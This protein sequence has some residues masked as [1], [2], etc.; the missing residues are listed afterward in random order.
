VSTESQQA[1]NQ[2]STLN[3]KPL[4]AALKTWYA[5]PGDRF[6]V[7]V[8]GFIVDIV[9]DELLVEIQTRNFSA[10]KRKLTELVAHHPVRLVHPIAREKWIVKVAEDQR[11][12]LSRRKSP[13]RCTWQAVFE[14]LVSFPSLLAEANFSLEVVLIQEEEVRRHDDR[15]GWR[16]RGWVT[17][18]RRLLHVVDRRIFVRP[19]D[20]ADL[21]PPT[22][23]EP[24][25]TADLAAA[26]ARPRRLAQKM[27][28]CLREMG[29]I[30]PVSKQGN[31]F[32]YTR[33]VT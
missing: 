13:K 10:I 23:A 12:Q 25:T 5:Q 17:Q 24:F 4:H 27:A 2:I 32:L 18:E 33:T 19:A 22:V 31:A 16:R 3:E 11:T 1:S 21:I 28:Y 9:R 20:M 7:A 6:E 15:R 8:D 30:E 29:V 26:L 14:E